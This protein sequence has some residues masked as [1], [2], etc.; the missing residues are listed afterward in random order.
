MNATRFDRLTRLVAGRRTRRQVVRNSGIAAASGA[1]AATGLATTVSAQDATPAAGSDSSS[2]GPSL[3]FVQAASSGTL[4][5]KAG[6]DG[7]YTLT[8]DHAVGQTVYFADRPDR[9]VGSFPTAAFIT[10]S[11]LFTGD[12]PPNAALV[13]EREPGVTDIAVIELLSSAYDEVAQT[14]TY[15]VVDL[16]NFVDDWS[17]GLVEDPT[18]LAA[19][20]PEF[21][22]AHLFIDSDSGWWIPCSPHIAPTWCYRDGDQIGEMFYL[23]YEGRPCGGSPFVGCFP[24]NGGCANDMCNERYLDQCEGSCYSASPQIQDCGY[25]AD[26]V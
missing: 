23:E 13:V 21:G 1:L 18:D 22:S 25:C 15:D 20:L 11:S 16:E 26:Q 3:L 17:I 7:V 12:D 4:T 10:T 14:L 6:E 5:S 9:D 8:L 2:D 24:H 19:F